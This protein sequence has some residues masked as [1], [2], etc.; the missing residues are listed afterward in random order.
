MKQRCLNPNFHKYPM[1]GGSG[2]KVDINWH[3]YKNFYRDMGSRPEGTT[4]D[5]I[6]NNGNYCKENCRWST[7]TTQQNN[8]S[9]NHRIDYNGESITLAQA[10]ALAGLKS[11]VLRSRIVRLGWSLDRAMR[12]PQKVYLK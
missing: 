6:N 7:P 4:L 9:V 3:D 8:R 10:S 2:I 5:R 11:G 12:T 1:Y